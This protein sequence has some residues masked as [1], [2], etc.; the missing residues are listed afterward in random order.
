MIVAIL[1]DAKPSIAYL[2]QSV[3]VDPVNGGWIVL[4]LSG[5]HNRTRQIS[6][7]LHRRLELH[8]LVEDAELVPDG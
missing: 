6:L 5:F 1:K 4:E 2:C 8:E 7:P 3:R